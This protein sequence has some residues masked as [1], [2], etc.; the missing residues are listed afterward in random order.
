[1]KDFFDDWHIFGYCIYKRK[2]GRWLVSS[3]AEFDSA[4]KHFNA[5]E[6]ERRIKRACIIRAWKI[7]AAFVAGSFAW[8]VIWSL[9]L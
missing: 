3:A 1:M 4:L 8:A 9:L 7:A 5:C 6:R 2:G